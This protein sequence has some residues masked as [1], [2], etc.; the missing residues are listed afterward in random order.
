[1]Y[2]G[3][4]LADFYDEWIAPE[5]ERYRALYLDRLLSL[6]RQLRSRGDYAQAVAYA[7]KLLAADPA[8]EPAHQN[9]MFCLADEMVTNT[10]DIVD[11]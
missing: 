2:R 5:R 7:E 1:L 8:H 3:D 4:L 10:P 11:G 6:T 9:L